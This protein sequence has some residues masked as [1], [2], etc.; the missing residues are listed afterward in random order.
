MTP[1]VSVVVAAVLLV[2]LSPRAA[3]AQGPAPPATRYVLEDASLFEAGCFDLCACPVRQ[4]P[5]KGSFVLTRLA[6]DPMFEHYQVSEVD[7]IA[8]EPNGPVAITGSGSYRVGGE[9]AVQHQLT[10]DLALGSAAP[11]LFDSGLILGGGEF[12]RIAIQVRLHLSPAC[13]DTLLT[14][15]ASP[16]VAGIDPGA[17]GLPAVTPNPFRESARVDFAVRAAGP[18][19]VSILDLGGRVVR[20]LVIG[21]WLEAGKRSITWDGRREGGAAAAAGLYYVRVRS[22]G[23]EDLQGMIKL[24]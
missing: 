4:S 1:R 24:R 21:E 9:F 20:R 18:V 17:R 16:A 22:G 11:Q 14:V 12:P 6:P 19:D 10:L 15:R 13:T 7:L 5:L 23:R 8:Q 2:A 3:A